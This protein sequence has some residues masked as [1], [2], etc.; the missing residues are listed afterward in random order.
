[1]LKSTL[2]T[3]R[4]STDMAP[5]SSAG[6]ASRRRESAAKLCD[7]TTSCIVVSPSRVASL[8]ASRH[9]AT[10]SGVFFFFSRL[11]HAVN[12]ENAQARAV[13]VRSASARSTLASAR[14]RASAATRRVASSQTGDA[15]SSAS[16]EKTSSTAM[17][18]PPAPAAAPLSVALALTG[19][20]VADARPSLV[21]SSSVRVCAEASFDFKAP[22]ISLPTRSRE[23]FA[24]SAARTSLDD[25]AARRA[26]SNANP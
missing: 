3:S 20:N 7:A 19:R 8:S 14:R 1:M 18:A 23:T 25:A 22:L 16:S 5:A 4:R 6:V 17:A 21:S 24:R 2:P 15:A 9:M 12:G 13:G 11:S 10:G 26:S